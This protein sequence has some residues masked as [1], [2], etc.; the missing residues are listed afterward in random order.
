[1]MSQTLIE[2]EVEHPIFSFDKDLNGNPQISY[3][4]Q[5]PQPKNMEQGTILTKFVRWSLE[6]SKN[7]IIIKLPVG[8]TICSK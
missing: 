4:D 1:M 3:I 6:E 8:S 7:K 5:F 2:Y